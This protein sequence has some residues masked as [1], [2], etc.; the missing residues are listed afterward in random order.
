MGYRDDASRLLLCNYLLWFSG[1][2]DMFIETHH[3]S[4]RGYS[5]ILDAH[6]EFNPDGRH[7]ADC[8]HLGTNLPLPSP[9]LGPRHRPPSR[10]GTA[11]RRI[12]DASISLSLS[13]T[14]ARCDLL[15]SQSSN[16]WQHRGG[17]ASKAK[18]RL[19]FERDV[20]LG[21]TCLHSGRR[22]SGP[23][24]ATHAVLEPG[25]LA[26]ARVA[27]VQKPRRALRMR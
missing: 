6:P 23:D 2:R 3:P 21:G 12:A 26:R 15:R 7:V 22:Q 5:K 4:A 27:R 19:A 24:D 14:L 9:G 1:L 16:A 10:T 18:A 17:S 11:G 20:L 13:A 25:V 8:V